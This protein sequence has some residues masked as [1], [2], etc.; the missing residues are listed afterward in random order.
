MPKEANLKQV[1]QRVF[2]AAFEDGLWDVLIGL[3]TLQFAIGPLLSRSLGDFWSSAVFLPFF[4]L[5]FAVI[6]LV[7]KHIVR[8]RVGIVKF[9]EWRRKKLIRFNIAML[10]AFSVAL[11]LGILSFVSFDSVPG[12]VHATRFSFAVL[13]FSGIAAYLLNFTRLYV[14]GLL[15]ALSP[16]VGEW[17]WA[18]MGVPHHGF[19]VTFGVTAGIIIIIGLV[20][21]TRLLRSHPSIVERLSSEGTCDG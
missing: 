20:K 7:R 21:F 6:W 10:I 9:G 14:Y 19:P 3:M 8:P 18:H 12:W 1:E 13:L 5:A 4:A 11:I 2:Q 15:M 17:L 16:L